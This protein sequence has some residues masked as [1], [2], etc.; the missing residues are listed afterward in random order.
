MVNAAVNDHSSLLDPLSF[1]HLC[2]SN[3]DNQDVRF[4]HLKRNGYGWICEL[5]ETTFLTLILGLVETKLK[6]GYVIVFR[7]YYGSRELQNQIKLF[8]E[9]EAKLDKVFENE[10]TLNK[11]PILKW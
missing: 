4:S 1:H 3:T 9:F 10:N 2:F 11:S 7:R 8:E 5:D 6:M